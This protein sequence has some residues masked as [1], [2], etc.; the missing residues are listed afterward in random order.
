MKIKLP[1]FQ[2]AYEDRGAGMPMLLI[3]GYPLNNRMWQPQ[4]ENLSDCA[5][6][7]AP[8]L[9]GHG[10]S[11]FTSGVYTMDL[12]AQDCFELLQ[13]LEIQQKVV[14]CGLSMG[15]YVALAFYRLYPEKVAGL[16][17]ASTRAAADS[18]EAKANRD[19]SMELARQQ[20]ILP[21]AT[22][23]AERLLSAQTISTRPHL[24][25]ELIDLM[26]HN[27]LPAILGD[28]QGMK[29]RTDSLSLLPQIQ[30][31][32]QIIHGA[33]DTIIPLAEAIQMQSMLS[34]AALCVLSDSAHL[35]NIEQ[36][37]LFNN[38]VRAFLQQWKL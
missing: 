3:H 7:I 30:V 4:L 33:Q 23:M 31:P 5:R 17:L 10:D 20:G 28:L 34:H 37:E 22:G 38:S 9:R 19:K 29:E 35:P 6:L 18:Q 2:M 16:V 15:G 8:D 25:Q 13:A 21:I 27:S 24:V 14:L 11:E 1:E 26:T 36:P 12:L 32:V